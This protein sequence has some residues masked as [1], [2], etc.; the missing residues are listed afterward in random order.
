M[1]MWIKAALGCWIT[2]ASTATTMAQDCAKAL[3]PVEK[4]VCHEAS[5]AEMDAEMNRLYGALRPQL[6]ARARAELLAQQR[7]WLAERNR[8]CANGDVP[9]L[10][11]S[12]GNRLDQL[13]ALTASAAVAED[14]LG[15]VVPVIVKGKWKAVGIKDQAA[16]KATD[17]STLPQYLQTAGLV[18]VGADVSMAPGKFCL[19]GEPCQQMGWSWTTLAKVADGE[20]VGRVFG[21]KQTSPILFGDS[22][23]SQAPHYELLPQSDKTVWAVFVLCG[24]NHK[25][26]RLAAEVWA[27]DSPDAAV[28]PHP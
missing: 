25:D 3:T 15:D 9:C 4:A 21:L 6:T 24:A 23:A 16:T 20:A 1:N 12:Y 28:Q 7:A 17:P 26:C 19:P 27:P 8:E 18:A 5:L 22:G 13:Q 2:I 10:R 11:R 14:K